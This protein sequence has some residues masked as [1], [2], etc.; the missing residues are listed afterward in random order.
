MQMRR[1]LTAGALTTAAA[2]AAV[3]A[4][5]AAVPS[6]SYQLGGVALGNSYFGNA[7]GSTGDRATWQAT[8]SNA[9][10]GTLTLRSAGQQLTGTLAGVQTAVASAAP[11]CGRQTV[12]LDAAVS[13]A[14]GPMTLTGTITRFRFQLGRTCFTLLSTVQATLAAV[15]TPPPPTDGDGQL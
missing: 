5:S 1:F 9:G 7:Q 15:S 10:G 4:A 3:T 13:T 2:L 8:L 12:S 6:P 11:G 14:D